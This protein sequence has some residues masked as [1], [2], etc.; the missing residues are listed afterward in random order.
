MSDDDDD[1]A[2]LARA[3]EWRIRRF[4]P[5]DQETYQLITDLEVA[6]RAKVEDFPVA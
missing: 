4:R 1:Q 6:L 3:R 2:V 5:S